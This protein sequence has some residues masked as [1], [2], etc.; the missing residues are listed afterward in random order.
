MD[1][2]YQRRQIFG[3]R[4][5]VPNSILNKVY[6]CT[7]SI[8]DFFE[9][10][11]DDKIPITCII[12]SDRQIVEKFGLE[13]CKDLDW[14]TLQKP[15]YYSK[16]FQSAKDALMSID[17]NVDNINFALYELV[18]DSMS[19]SMYSK[20]MAEYFPDRLFEVSTI[21][22][23]VANDPDSNLK[24]NFN[25]GRLGLIEILNNWD[26]FKNKDLSYCLLRDIYNEKHIT[27]EILKKFMSN[28]GSLAPIL[29]KSNSDIYTI[30]ADISSITS[31]Q[32]KNNYLKQTT[33]IILSKTIEDDWGFETPIVLA[34]EEYQEVFKYSSMEEYL[35]QFNEWDPKQIVKELESL[36]QDYIFNMPIPFKTLLSYGVLHF[37]GTYGLKNIIDFDNE[38]G[39]FFTKDNCK[40]LKLMNDMYLRHASYEHDQNRTILTKATFDENGNFN[41][42]PYTKDEFYE[43]M[44]R[45]IKYGPSS[46]RGPDYRDLTGEFREKNEDLFISEQAPEELQNLFYAK[47]ITPR[48]LLEHC[49][50]I[51]YLKGKDLSSCFIDNT[52]EVY[53][54]DGFRD[55]ENF[56]E[57]L[58]SK[59]DYDSL[60]DFITDY[61]DV[62]DIIFKQENISNYSINFSTEDNIDTIKDKIDEMLKKIIIEEK[63]PYPEHMP[64]RIIKKNPSMFLDINAPQE[65]KKAFYD[66][67]ISSSFIKSNPDYKEYLSSIDLE[68]LFPYMPIHYSL[69][70][71]DPNSRMRSSRPGHSK[72]MNIVEALEQN[73]GKEKAF[74]IMLEYGDYL[75]KVFEYD[76]LSRFACGYSFTEED[77]LRQFDQVI[78][79]NILEVNK[80]YDESMPDHFKN[81]YPTMFLDSDTPSIIKEK[82]YNK[83]LSLEYINNNPELLNYF[84]NTN[85]GFGFEE[86]AWLSQLFS[87]YDMERAN[88][89]RL[90]VLDQYL[91]IN[92]S[93]MKDLFVDYIIRQGNKLDV[94]KIDVVAEVLSKLEYSNSLEL[95]SF[96]LPLANQLLDTDDPLGN[97][98]KIESIFLRNNLP[99]CGKMYLCFQTLYPNM[100]EISKFD[101]SSDSR[102]A[103]QLKDDTLP[104]FVFNTNSD[105]RRLIIIFNDLLRA[106]YRSNERSLVEYLNII[107]EGNDLY[108]KL[109]N[110]NYDISQLSD[111]EKE[112]LEVFVSHLEVLY[113]NTQKGKL[114]ELKIKDLP[115]EGKLK[116]LCEEF[117]PSESYDLKDRIVRSFCYLAGVRSFDELEKL[118]NDSYVEQKTRISKNLKELN[119][120]PFK[121]EEGDIVRGIGFIDALSSS[122]NTGNFSK[123]HLGVFM[124]T[125]DSDTTPLDVDL[126]L[127]TKTDNI[128]NAIEGTPTGFGFGNI[129][130]IIKKDNSNF[131][132]SRDRY[133]TLTK[134]KYDPKRVEIFGTATAK[135]GYET[136]WGARTGFSLADIDYILFKE[137]KQIDEKHPYDEEGNVNYLPL[138]EEEEKQFRYELP[139]V[140][141]EIARNGYYIPVIDFSGK[142]IFTEKEY[143]ELREKMQGLSYYNVDD[144]KISEELVTPE[145]EEIV[146][147]ITE[148]AVNSTNTKRSEITSIVKEVLDEMGLT[149]KYKMD[150]DLSPKS[151]E[152]IDT[153]ST[154][155]NTNVPYDGD[156][157]FYMRLDAEIMRNPSALSDF[158]NRL[159]EKFKEHNIQ[160]CFYTSRGDLRI[161]DLELDTGD[162]VDIDISFGVKTNKVKY[163][164]DE[165]LKDRLSTIKKLY[166]DKY[167]YVVANIILG[168]KFFKLPEVDAYKPRRTDENQGGLGGIGIENWILQNGG[169]FIQACRS[170]VNA[171]INEETGEMKSF[172]DFKKG[173]QIWDFGEN[174][175]SARN[176]YYLYDNFVE[177]NMNET[178]YKKM[179]TA[180]KNYLNSIDLEYQN[181]KSVKR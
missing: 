93:R 138:S 29:L 159:E 2:K 160:E 100:S 141:F 90:K 51:P 21:D 95:S 1:Y 65:L 105:K 176:G 33:D 142:V 101:F 4:L 166:P 44:R 179:V 57:F 169:S 26:L 31:E 69:P 127:V 49:D 11:L 67:T 149:I 99:L 131:Y 104:N 151:V 140:K 23:N 82:F 108:I 158:K 55:Y 40:V 68:L 136:H 20:R 150:G 56:Y 15:L 75:E 7:L 16:V 139:A 52:I 132:V 178:G 164:S 119:G 12:E 115:L 162:K 79:T 156:F 106:S 30:I 134:A 48:V 157:D 64:E 39:H 86:G 85:I 71:N 83:D 45:I 167:E 27:D 61:C 78:Y 80:N 146:S 110:N 59:T 53:N 124:G 63:T 144:Y 25:A 129:F 172:E 111:K 28:Y 161:K 163:S 177:N 5:Q 32:E 98:D 112:V 72:Q 168:K 73:L 171:A 13:K 109:Q 35:R 42:K 77:F 19:P 154:G 153:G 50:Y 135:G 114:E 84:K 133:G 120:G 117:K 175:F 81:S 97:L 54:I 170:F 58:G 91:K 60:M 145:V 155:R 143:E 152:L 6:N 46:G 125:S 96:K 3:K 126:T 18:K 8:E 9:Y 113:Q 102:V 165:C 181:S 122:L 36:P 34:K 137:R 70:N 47:S 24:T 74:D 92:N 118:I 14:E 76:R 130:V 180:M 43:A 148:D 10:Q 123:E 87:S 89:Y 62:F 107:K 103:P 121:F 88:G 17:P 94:D 22:S 66:R 147:T 128:Y 174:H 116:V 41:D 37:I 173:Y 38:C